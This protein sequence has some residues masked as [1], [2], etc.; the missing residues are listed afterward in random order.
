MLN[1]LDLTNPDCSFEDWE[2]IFVLNFLSSVKLTDACLPYM[3]LK[4]GE[5]L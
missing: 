5:G 2:R 3:K 4:S 1:T